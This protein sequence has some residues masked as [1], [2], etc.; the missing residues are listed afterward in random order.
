MALKLSET[1]MKLEIYDT[2]KD[3][4]E[5]SLEDTMMIDIS[6]LLYQEKDLC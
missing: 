1:V 6:C 3:T 5:E 4:M 2:N